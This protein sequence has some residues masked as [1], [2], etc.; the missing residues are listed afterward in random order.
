MI[1]TK[2]YQICEILSTQNIQ[3]T[4]TRFYPSTSMTFLV[5]KCEVA[6]NS[7][8]RFDVP[9][10]SRTSR[11]N[12]IQTLPNLLN[13]EDID[14]ILSPPFEVENSL[15][16]YSSCVGIYLQS[17]LLLFV[18]QKQMTHELN[19]SPNILHQNSFEMLNKIND[20]KNR[21]YECIAQHIKH[22]S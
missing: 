1:K 20:E 9:T 16:R 19:L 12:R 18:F 14:C 2:V 6:T 8:H 13:K 11:L 10:T 4:N 15:L 5:L 3:H 22:G 21:H 7:N 17:Y